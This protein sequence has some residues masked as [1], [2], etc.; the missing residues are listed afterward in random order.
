M[1]SITQDPIDCDGL[2]KSMHT[3]GAGAIAIFEGHVRIKNDGRQVTLL[4]Y[5]GAE[6]L[7]Q[8]EF[9]KIQEETRKRFDILHLRCVHRIG[10]LQV[11]D[12]AVW[13]GV[14]SEHR[15]DAFDACRY[16]IEELKHRLPIWK[17]E[18]YTD[19]DS[20]WINSP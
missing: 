17:K 3:S 14:A 5:E 18:H 13:I 6:K 11:G 19:G 8:N 12:I 15:A 16:L 7:A 4:E 9:L 2:K 10:K 20:G 1:F